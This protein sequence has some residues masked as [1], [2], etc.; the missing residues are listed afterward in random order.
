M[1]EDE[2]Q[3]V[4]DHYQLSPHP[5]GGWFRRTYSSG[6]KV[7]L[8]RG[9]R[10]CGTSIYYYLKHGEKSCLHSIESDETW[11]FHFGVSVRLHLF[12][13]SDYYTIVLG[14]NWRRGEVV[15]FTVI[16]NTIFG[17]ELLGDGGALMSCSVCPGFIK[18]DFHWS[19]VKKLFLQFPQHHQVIKQLQRHSDQLG[20]L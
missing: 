6:N 18:E 15:Q 17:A 10:L 1:T 13:K 11:Y 19:S 2:D 14:H 16:A 9:E 20:E 3:K 8:V 4:V 5:E 7:S 12:L